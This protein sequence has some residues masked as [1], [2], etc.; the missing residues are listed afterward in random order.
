MTFRFSKLGEY[1]VRVDVPDGRGGC[2][3]H[4]IEVYG[5]LAEE[6]RVSP[7]IFVDGEPARPNPGS[8]GL[9][10]VMRRDEIS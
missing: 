4:D 2:T 10:R 6:D 9:F 8:E 3:S 7:V 5:W 1:F